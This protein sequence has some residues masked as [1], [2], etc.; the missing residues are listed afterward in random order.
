[1]HGYNA[2]FAS[3]ARPT[4]TVAEGQERR[5]KLVEQYAGVGTLLWRDRRVSRVPYK[6]N[7][8]QGLT[9]AGLPVPG[10]HRIEGTIEM[11]EVEDATGLVGS[12]FTLELEDGRS[13]NLTLA[14]SVG[15]V[16]AEGHGPK[17]GC[18]CC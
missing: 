6:I 16:L 9:S 3:T 2:L 4:G 1:M 12:A 11:R 8:F 5:L 17:H 18:S 7:R 13:L 14:D 10:L 15:R